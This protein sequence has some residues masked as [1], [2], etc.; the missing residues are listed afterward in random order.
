VAAVVHPGRKTG[1]AASRKS[2]PAKRQHASLEGRQW[3][4]VRFEDLVLDGAAAWRQIVS[5]LGAENAPHNG[6]DRLPV[7]GSSFGQDDAA[8]EWQVR[9]AEH[10][11]MPVGRWRQWQPDVVRDIESRIGRQLDA[12]GY[13]SDGATHTVAGIQARPA[14]RLPSGRR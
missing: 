10:D 2:L 3:L 11:F 1:H 7:F 13:R 4:L 9:P 6:F 14:G 5:F 12:L 8:F